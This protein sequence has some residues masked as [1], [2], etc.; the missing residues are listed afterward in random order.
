MSNFILPIITIAYFLLG[1]FVLIKNIRSSTNRIFS[2]L[3]FTIA[4]WILFL[5]LSDINISDTINFLTNK[6]V[7]AVGIPSSLIF[8]YFTENFP[9]PSGIKRIIRNSILWS[10]VTTFFILTVFTNLVVS[11]VEIYKNGINP[12]L[13]NLYY[14]IMIFDSYLLLNGIKNLYVKYG[15]SVGLAKY[16]LQYM[17]FGFV[18]FCLIVLPLNL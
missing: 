3:V 11:K 4:L 15:K 7:L 13:G 16:Q 18:A 5:Y 2:F 9:E 6:L 17:I 14:P 12:I 10:I 1:I 8:L